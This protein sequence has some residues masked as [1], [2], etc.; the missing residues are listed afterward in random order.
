MFSVTGTSGSPPTPTSDSSPD[1]TQEIRDASPP[2]DKA[3]ADVILRSVDRVDFRVRKAILAEASPIFEAMFG[4]PQPEKTEMGDDKHVAEYR[5]NLP[6]VPM[7]EG[8]ATLDNLLR[9][10]Y[11]VPPPSL[12]DLAELRRVLDAALKYDMDGVVQA[13][14]VQMRSLVNEAGMP[15]RIY[16]ISIQY[17]FDEEVRLAA[18]CS[19][20]QPIQNVYSPEL[21]EITAGAYY[22]L[23]DYHEQCQGAVAILKY[24]YHE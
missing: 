24:T 1:H 7:E 17:K 12:R 15:L 22:R 19:L 11:P 13:I 14:R 10:C 5:D 6:V 18:L 4:L 2:F 16:A 23:L 8:S 3:T 21:E 20:A 9:L